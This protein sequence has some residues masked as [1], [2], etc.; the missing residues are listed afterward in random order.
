MSTANTRADPVKF[1]ILGCANIARQFIRDIKDSPVA[2]VDAVASRNGDNA[3]SFAAETGVERSFASY[4]RM[5]EDPGIEAIYLPLPNS[6]HAEWAIK[7]ANAG[8]HVMCEKPLAV[9]RSEAEKMFEAA[10]C[11]GTVLLEA[12]PYWFQPQIQVLRDLIAM[13]TIG[14]V[15][16]VSASFGFQVG[17]PDTNIRLKPELG[18]GALLDAGSYTI[19]FIRLI[20]GCAP[21]RI[22]ARS[23][24][25]EAGVDISTM[26]LFE[27]A[28][29]RRAQISCAMDGA[30]H[31][32]ATV[33]G[34]DGS[35]YT[36]YLNHTSD[37]VG[38]DARG[39]LPSRMM[40]RRGIAQTIP[41]ENVESPSGSGFR[42][43]VE[44]FAG[45]LR[46]SISREIIG[47]A[48]RASLDIAETL[49]A[50][51]TSASLGNTVFI[52]EHK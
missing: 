25:T 29:G 35:I 8:K 33:V 31:R 37:A 20:M 45:L 12:Y 19:S 16:S 44:T 3:R 11:N 30:N 36:E 23:L 21:S 38:A 7:A 39:Y 40:I 22:T 17:N 34:S 18:G 15:R 52:D 1:G 26:A 47:E 14:T 48:R 2:V 5:L 9:S 51:R 24:M 46:G 4:E 13:G 43:A 6:M 10:D 32:H 42:F 49:D 50:V 28:D 27:Y 41:F